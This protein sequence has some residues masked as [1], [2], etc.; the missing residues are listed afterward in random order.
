MHPRTN[1]DKLTR[2]RIYDDDGEL[3]FSGWFLGDSEAEEAL[4]IASDF[5]GADL[6][7]LST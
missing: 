2:F 5:I 7:R 4:P 6:L 3:Y 1:A